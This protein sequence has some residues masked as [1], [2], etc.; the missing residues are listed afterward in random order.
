MV[1]LLFHSFERRRKA[2]RG[3]SEGSG[4]LRNL[5]EAKWVSEVGMKNEEVSPSDS[6][7][8]DPEEE[9]PD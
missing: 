8:D 3:S 5:G 9:E 7:E 2:G 1:W 6:D 4:A